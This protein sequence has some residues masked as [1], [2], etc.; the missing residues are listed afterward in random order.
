MAI[1][2]LH[3]TS[4]ITQDLKKKIVILTGPRQVGKTTLSRSLISSHQYLNYDF[5]DDRVRILKNDWDRSKEL[6]IL[7]E[8]HKKK[9][10]K[11]WIKGIFD[12]QARP[13][14]YLIT[15]SAKLDVVKKT[16]DSLAG[17]FYQHR[18]HPFDLKELKGQFPSN[19]IFEKLM[20]RGGFPEPFLASSPEEVD[21]WRRT[22]LNMILRQDLADLESVRNIHGIETLM[23]L[24]R[25]RVGS[26]VSFA[27]LARDLEV[28]P[29]TVKNWIRI[30]EELYVIF[31]VSPYTTK[32]SRSI[33][34][35]PKIYFYDNGQLIGDQGAKF[36][37]LVACA[38][39]KELQSLEDLKGKTVALNY[40]R[41]KE[42]KEV[43]FIVSIDRRPTHLIEVKWNDQQISPALIH[44]RD[45][46]THKKIN[47][48]IK[49]IQLVANLEN[50]KVNATGVEVRKAISWLENISL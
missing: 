8:V 25:E 31:V 11:S 47:P 39:L 22:H 50:E 14:Y 12:T 13:P 2:S 30:L 33:L 37:N 4:Q 48:D 46:F 9:N 16:G 21:R 35:E 20:N 3:Q 26:G 43:D 18:L 1:R 49:A 28:D 42:K 6:I 36:E 40:L 34:K 32:I 10:W 23:L 5:Y 27:S 19:V 41:N 24:L 17:R 29:K 45:Y 44:F 38:L 7:D 15:G